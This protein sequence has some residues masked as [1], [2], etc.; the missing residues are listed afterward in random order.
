[1][2]NNP[3]I[4]PQKEI[5]AIIEAAQPSIESRMHQMS[6]ADW[7]VVWSRIDEGLKRMPEHWQCMVRGDDG[8]Q[9][10]TDRLRM[11]A[12][13][14][15]CREDDG[16]LWLHLSVS[17]ERGVP[18]WEQMV[19]AKNIFLG[20]DA[21]AVQIFPRKANYVNLH[22]YVLHLWECLDADPVPDFS[23]GTGSI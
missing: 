12:I 4:K 10:I 11:K 3:M 8:I 21:L 18:N 20:E 17:T 23:S 16:K 14:S 22:K 1:M 19:K 6:S 2:M 7:R 15:G 13:F 9:C 5:D